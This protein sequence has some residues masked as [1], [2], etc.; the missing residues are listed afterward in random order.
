MRPR[1]DEAVMARKAMRP[2]RKGGIA[3]PIT[4]VSTAALVEAMPI[5]RTSS[6]ISSC[7]WKL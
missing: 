4:A 7:G 1:L 3:N 2:N 6:P 5:R